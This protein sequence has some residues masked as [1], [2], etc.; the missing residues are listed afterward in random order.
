MYLKNIDIQG[1][2][3]FANKMNLQF[4]TGITGIVG[5]NG[6]GKSN[7]ADAVRW[8]L[9]E[10]SAKQ[11]RG[12]KMEDVI[13]SG[14][15]NRRPLGYA[16][17]AITIDNSD[18][19]LP[20]DF[21]EV[22]VARKVF[23]SG[24]SEY[25]INGSTC[26][27][28]DVQELFF[29]TGIGREGYSIIGQGQVDHIVN[30]K[31]EERRE[32]FDEAAGIVKYKKRKNDAEKKLNDSMS[33]LDR[34]NDI[35]S[36]LELQVGPLEEQSEIAKLYLQ[37]KEEQKQHDV[38]IFIQ[39]YS[40]LKEQ[41]TILE[42]KE[43]IVQQ[44]LEHTNIEYEA[45]K[46]QHDS[47]QEENESLEVR[48][49]EVRNSFSKDQIAVE[50]AEGEIKVMNEQIGAL[51]IS[52]DQFTNRIQEIK[53]EIEDKDCE[54][55][56]IISKKSVLDVKLDDLINKQD[57]IEEELE[58]VSGRISQKESEA[59]TNQSNI[60]EFLNQKASVDAKKQR[61]ETMREQSNFKKIEL[62]QKHLKNKSELEL[63]DNLRNDFLAELNVHKKKTAE[64]YDYK[65]MS[66]EELNKIQIKLQEAIQQQN[67]MQ[68]QYHH[69]KSTLEAKQGV[70]EHYDGYSEAIKQIMSKKAANQ[71]IIGV[72]ADIIKVKKQYETSIETALGASIQN[73]VT[74]NES[75]AKALIEFLKKNKLGRATFL[76]LSSLS[77]RPN[78]NAKAI[79]AEKGVIGMAS[80]LIEY[81]DSYKNLVESLVGRVVVVDTIENAI[82][83]ARKYNQS[84]RIVTLEGE[85]FSPGGAI[86]GGNMRHKNNL[87]GRK[88]EIEELEHQLIH[89]EKE[90]SETQLTIEKLKE[91][92]NGVRERLVSIDK[93]IQETAINI[94]SATLNLKQAENRMAEIA[95]MKEDII[96][97]LKQIE[98]QLE[99]LTVA[100]NV[101]LEQLS[102][103]EGKQE[104]ANLLIK[105]LSSTI[106]QERE[107]ESK[108]R[109]ALNKIKV[110]V[111]ALEVDNSHLIE[112]IKR[113]TREKEKLSDEITKLRANIA[114]NV[115]EVQKKQKNMDEI[116][117]NVAASKSKIEANSKLI[118]EL[119]KEKEKIS[120]TLRVY[121][122]KRDEFS[123]KQSNLDKDLFRI[124]AAKEKNNEQNESI[125]NYMWE[126]YELTYSSAMELKGEEEQPLSQLRKRV[127]ELKNSIKDLG[128]VNVN[129]IED[130]KN[131]KERYEQMSVQR[132]DLLL[133]KDNLLEIIEEL[134]EAMRNQFAENFAKI[135]DRFQV[136]F[137]ELFGGGKAS[138]ELVE[139][140]DILEAGVK[141]IAQPPGKKLQNMI[142][143]SG[144]EKAFTAIALLFAIQSLKPSP[145]CLLDEIEAALDDS[146]VI[147]FANYLGKLTKDTQFIIITHRKGTMEAAD[148]LYGIT[149]QEKGISTLVSVKLI[150]HELDEM[151][152]KQM[153]N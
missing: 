76:P 10:Q 22:T 141:I 85:S 115:N 60:I 52:I 69:T 17:V 50:K 65:N 87:L 105:T 58:R 96:K 42:E 108:V 15:E 36:E 28:K 32:L 152:M 104:E 128:I 81:D 9:G 55:A 126:E 138:L 103:F 37:Y 119:S 123:S 112:N 133:A 116:Q 98:E 83:L 136:V 150:E 147:R 118:E 21:T 59:N 75:T 74:D 34:V 39:E 31:P 24:E 148:A 40:R 12:S 67:K 124:S 131:V 82:A 46:K 117:A 143:L 53:T 94:N 64:L 78:Q 44:D 121:F 153:V 38:A 11:L 122:T 95:E 93:E 33:N 20:I 144:G 47:F 29:D 92:K 145:F 7:V 100:E 135:Q 139:G 130:Y 134:D 107:E 41:I 146:N 25:S 90:L 127:T 45:I 79:Q 51:K 111:S 129:A 5:P 109:E 48:L 99:E 132:E 70:V 26:R 54:K 149:M 101:L 68:E 89:I 19:K 30:S 14:T 125:I 72:V 137:R 23:R 140:E 86:T 114:V 113:L 16:Q 84:L 43:K 120:K 97:E 77:S 35:I 1:F 110:E 57:E 62:N 61:F 71:G 106:S 151:E 3:S 6:S 80:T 66:Q 18:S 2:K 8:V 49:Q 27:L 88:R 63:Q 13:F 4:N 91:N 102:D 56:E 73:V 142:L